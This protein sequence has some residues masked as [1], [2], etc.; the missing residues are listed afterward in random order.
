M[1]APHAHALPSEA[2]PPHAGARPC[3]ALPPGADWTGVS[4]RL[5]LARRIRL[6][7]AA[8][9]TAAAIGAGLAWA[10]AAGAPSRLWAILVL[11]VIA[12]LTGWPIIGRQ[13][14]AWGYLEREADLLVRSGVLIQRLVIVPYGRMQ[15]VDVTAGPLERWLG[16]ATVQLHTAAA[17]TDATIPGLPPGQAAGLRDRLAAQGE[18]RSAGM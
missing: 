1:D 13:V 15:M 7:A 2:L 3:D 18:S 14:R 9:L 12:V 17:T 8:G 6:C 10:T 5:A 4:P 16:L 11:P